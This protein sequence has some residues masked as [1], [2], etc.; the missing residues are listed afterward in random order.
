MKDS[1]LFTNIQ[2]FA[3]IKS[4]EMNDRRRNV[5]R[6]NYQICSR[7]G[8]E[9]ELRIEGILID[10]HARNSKL[11]NQ[12]SISDNLL[13][14]LMIFLNRGRFSYKFLLKIQERQKWIKKKVKV[15][16][17]L[18]TLR[19]KSLLVPQF[20]PLFFSAHNFCGLKKQKHP[21]RNGVFLVGKKS[22]NNI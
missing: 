13:A 10:H 1:L 8:V 19:P 3:I 4:G 14:P 12:G 9:R 5:R 17:V 22:E 6:D 18:V 11:L 21:K 2:K 20:P 16:Q 15:N 7:G